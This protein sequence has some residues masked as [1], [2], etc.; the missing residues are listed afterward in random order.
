MYLVIGKVLQMPSVIIEVLQNVFSNKRCITKCQFSATTAIQTTTIMPVRGVTE[1][2][3][4]L[5]FPLKSIPDNCVRNN[6]LVVVKVLVV[7]A[8]INENL[9][10]QV[11]IH[12]IAILGIL[13]L[14]LL[15]TTSIMLVRYGAPAWLKGKVFDS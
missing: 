3:S 4:Y 2:H 11:R 10:T 12:V 1:A 9:F 8:S 14:H 6:F 5:A 15:R 13:A 7:E